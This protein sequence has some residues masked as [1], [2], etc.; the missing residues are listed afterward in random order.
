MKVTIESDVLFQELEGELVLLNLANEQYFGLDNIG[1]RIWNLL[2]QD[3][4]V[5]KVI[6]SICSEYDVDLARATQD[7]NA[8]LEA[9]A[10]ANLVVI[11]KHG[12]H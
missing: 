2:E 3:Q 6:E 5:D 10:E 8:L 11:D 7:I 12:D 4:S 1:G 9:L